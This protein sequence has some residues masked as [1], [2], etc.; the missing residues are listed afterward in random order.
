MKELRAVVLGL[1]VVILVA[2]A[3][4]HWQRPAREFHRIRGYRVE[5]EKREGDTRKHV[6]FSIP[7]VAVARIASL[8]PLHEFGGRWDADWSNGSVTA[9]DILD[10]SRE[11]APGKPGVIEKDG[12]RIEVTADGAALDIRVQDDWGKNVQVRAPRAILEAFTEGGRMSV[13]EVLRKLDELG[14]GDVVRIQDGDN[15]VTITAQAR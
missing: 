2:L 10:A 15:E 11:S 6:S 13:H 7:I 8:V 9:K 5:I 14:P 1:V 4:A 3:W 12:H